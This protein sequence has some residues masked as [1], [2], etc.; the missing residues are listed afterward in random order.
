MTKLR[1]YLFLFL[2][3]MISSS[4]HASREKLG[5]NIKGQLE[6]F[7]IIENGQKKVIEIDEKTQELLRE[8]RL[9]LRK[10]E[11]T[12]L[13]N[14][15][16]R[17]LI[18]SQSDE[19]ISVAKQIEEL[20]VTNQEV[21]PLMGVMVKTLKELVAVDSPF[22]KEERT[23]RVSELEAMMDRADVTNSEKYRRILEAYMIENDFGKTL[24]AYR[25][26]LVQNDKD[27]TVDFL[28]VGR[29][30]YL[31]QTLDGADQAI[32]DNQKR[33]W[34]ELGGAYRTSIR[35]ALKIARKQTAPDLIKLPLILTGN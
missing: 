10:I 31:Y 35:D 13:Y 14:E 3:F 11:N 4:L 21:V 26:T 9:T 30:M 28:R 33:Q 2:V 5:A 15:Q 25:G 17:K 29:V 19:K 1:N 34:I 8:Y 12:K 23:K 16:L 20:Q 22:L 7:E 32:W 27:L 6:T 18:A 24:E